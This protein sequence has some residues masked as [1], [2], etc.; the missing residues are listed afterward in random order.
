M[1]SG[2]PRL[3]VRIA[4]AGLLTIMVVGCSGPVRLTPPTPTG[5]TATICR[6]LVSA[7]PDVVD[8]Q[9]RVKTEPISPYTSAWGKPA[10]TLACGVG[11]PAGLNAASQCFEVNGVGW[12][13][14][15]RNGDY[16]FTTI[17]RKAY[18]QVVVPDKYAPQANPLIDLAKPIKDTVPVIKNCV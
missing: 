5:G 12:Y 7:T 18:V 11:K 13:A 3:T 6:H 14:E 2:L 15:D 16:R 8:D 17:G 4:L 10:I 1:R 9:D